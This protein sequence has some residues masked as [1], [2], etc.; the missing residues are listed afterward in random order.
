[1]V[2]YGLLSSSNS[3]FNDAMGLLCSNLEITVFFSR[4]VT[5]LI[6]SKDK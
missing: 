4:H 2:V 3:L 1:M 6:V 5:V